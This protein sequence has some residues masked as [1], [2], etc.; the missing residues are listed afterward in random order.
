MLAPQHSLFCHAWAPR[1]PHARPAR[2]PTPLFRCVGQSR[3]NL[4]LDGRGWRTSTTAGGGRGAGDGAPEAPPPILGPSLGRAP[5][6]PADAAAHAPQLTPP[7]PHHDTIDLG[8]A[9]W[10]QIWG[11][12]QAWLAAAR[13]R[14]F[15]HY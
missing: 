15:F 9:R 14:P 1:H 8:I 7:P 3:A 4:A 5:P 13:A 6:T 2:A 10:T 11:G 12:Y